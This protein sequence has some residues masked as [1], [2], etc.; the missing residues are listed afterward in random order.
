MGMKF[1]FHL[2]FQISAGNS[3]GED[4]L[5]KNF[6]EVGGNR[7]ILQNE[8]FQI[9]IIHKIEHPASVEFLKESV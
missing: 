6:M 3:T 4:T 7:H 8:E 2:A 5:S 1:L 9:L